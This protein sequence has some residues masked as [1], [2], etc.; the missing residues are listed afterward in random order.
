MADR[1]PYVAGNWKMHKTRG[2]ARTYVSELLP[3]IEGKDAVEVGICVPYTTL[4]VCVEAAAGSA[5]RVFAQNAHEEGE[6]PFTG[7]IS[8][9]M[10]NDIG[11][12][13]AV[14]GHSERRQY[15]GETDK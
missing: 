10:L 12:H 2:D 1:R 11:V 13:G 9:V 14:L 8:T 15:F 4:D 6:G 7:E 3:L 5:L